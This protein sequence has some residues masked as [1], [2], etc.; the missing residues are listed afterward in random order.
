MEEYR[1]N[2]ILQE[3]VSD[4]LIQADAMSQKKP[5]ILSLRKIFKKIFE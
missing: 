1:Q 2:V 4:K 3:A 5:K